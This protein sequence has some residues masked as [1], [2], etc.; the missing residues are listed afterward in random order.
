LVAK[1]SALSRSSVRHG[2]PWGIFGPPVAVPEK[3]CTR[4]LR[5]RN[6]GYGYRVWLGSH[7]PEGIVGYGILCHEGI[8]IWIKKQNTCCISHTSNM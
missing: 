3:N 4:M 7:V 5:H 1:L 6:Y 2:R 8:R